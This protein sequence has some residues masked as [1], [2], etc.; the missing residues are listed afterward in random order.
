VLAKP[1]FLLDQ[2]TRDSID[3]DCRFS[4]ARILR[5]ADGFRGR[6]EFPDQ[7][8]YIVGRIREETDTEHGIEE[9]LHG[10]AFVQ[11]LWREEGLS[12][13]SFRGIRVKGDKL[14]RALS[15]TNRAEA[16]KVVLVRGRWTEAFLDEVC[17]FP[18]GPHDDQIDAVSLA[19]S[20][21]EFRKSEVYAF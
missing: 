3:D 17:R 11:E 7:R 5:I 6:L 14:T 13:F 8:K 12:R 20:M 2:A 9:A 18:H 21:M 16:G 4:S 19:V 10:Q 1:D 15:W